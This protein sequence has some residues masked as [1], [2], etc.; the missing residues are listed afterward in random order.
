M[1][2]TKELRDCDF[3]Q[4]FSEPELTALASVASQK[5]WREGE[6]LFQVGAPAVNLYIL[7]SGT[8]LLCFPNGRSMPLRERG[9]A[10][11]WSSLTSP[12]KITA[13]AVCLTDVNLYE[14]PGRELYRLIQMDASFGQRLMQK[15]AQVMENRK[16]YR[17]GKPTSE[18]AA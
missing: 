10:I 1:I 4:G 7:R 16:P 15:I 12:F 13:T 9:Q 3:L 2:S 14:F 17:Y 6:T 8:I 18:S 11:G 5:Q